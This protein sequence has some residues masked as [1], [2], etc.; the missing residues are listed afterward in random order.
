MARRGG[1]TT[2]VDAGS[3]GPGILHGFFR[4]VIKPL[5]LRI[6][7]FLNVSFP[8]HLRSQRRCVGRRVRRCTALDPR[9]CV[10]VIKANRDLIA[11]VKVRVG[12]NAGGASGI[13]PLDATVIEPAEGNFE[14]RDALGKVRARRRR[15][16]V[17]GL[18]VGGRWWHPQRT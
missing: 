9:E 14:Y 4:H 8:A 5:P 6:T 13:A 17:R 18:I 11:G 2:F 15:L 3:A 10:R 7:P 12:C 16:N 1:T